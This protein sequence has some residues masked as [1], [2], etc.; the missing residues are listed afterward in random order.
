MES[1]LKL[2]RWDEW[3]DSKI[4]LFFFVCY[5]LLL[6]HNKVQLQDMLLLLPLGIFYISLASFGFMLNDYSDKFVDTVSGKVN[7]MNRLSNRQQILVL[8]IALFVGLI[9]FIP[10][11]Q[12]KFAVI[13]TALSYLSSIL[14]SVHP[15]RLKEKGAWGIMCAS[16]AQWALPVLIVFGVFEYFGLDTLLFVILSFLIGLRWILVHQ[17][18][19]RDKDI[20]VSIKTFAINRSPTK[21]YSAMRFLFAI[22]LISMIGLL[23]VMAYTMSF[24]VLPP[25]VAY[26]IFEL[27]LSPLWKK[28]GFRRILTSYDFAPLA[29]FY[30]LWLPLWL[31]ILLGCLSPW[32]FIVTAIEILWKRDHIKLDVYLIRLGG[33]HNDRRSY[34]LIRERFR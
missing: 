18:I 21:I 27:Y 16:L 33:Q 24:K 11:Y 7:A 13:F 14:Y 23:G 22:E 5:Y 20:Q 6:L 19:D 3:Y 34:S 8:A 12:Y 9:A 17:L 10:F 2:I 28:L 29:D 4:A 30:F 25:I 31:S 26:I 32:F 1:L 15:F